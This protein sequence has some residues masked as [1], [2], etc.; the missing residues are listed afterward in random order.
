MVHSTPTP[1]LLLFIQYKSLVCVMI[2]FRIKEERKTEDNIK[3]P[4]QNV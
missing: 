4:Q 1:L 2:K 3:R